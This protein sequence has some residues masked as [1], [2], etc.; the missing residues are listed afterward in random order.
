MLFLVCKAGQVRG[1]PGESG[2]VEVLTSNTG[3]HEFDYKL[4]N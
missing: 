3:G 4:K 1:F 2:L